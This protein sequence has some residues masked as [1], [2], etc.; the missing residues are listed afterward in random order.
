MNFSD[1]LVKHRIN[2]KDVVVLRHRPTE[3][4]LRQQLRRIALEDENAFIAYQSSHRINTERALQ[5]AKFIASFLADGPGQAIFVGLYE[6]TEMEIVPHDRWLDNPI[7][8]SLVDGGSD[9]GET[10][11]HIGWFHQKRVS[12][13]DNWKGRLVVDWPPPE[14]SWYRRAHKNTFAI[15][16]IH[17]D[18]ELIKRLDSWDRL[19]FSWQELNSLPKRFQD[20]LAGWSGIYFIKDISDGMGYVGAAYGSEN[21][22]GRWKNYRQTGHGDNVLLRKRNPSTFQFSILERLANNIDEQKVF[23]RETSW[24]LRLGTRHPL[25]LNAN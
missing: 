12:F 19:V 25:G 2:P 16:T 13:Y 6:I 7:I 21:I 8:R 22:L 9:A 14:R 24:K 20:E 10:R 5:T 3:P 4:K 18:D 23:D 17:S 1:L 11:T 15:K